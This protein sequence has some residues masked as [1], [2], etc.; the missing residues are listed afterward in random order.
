MVNSGT[1]T[2][3]IAVCTAVTLS[4]MYLAYTY[5]KKKKHTK[6]NTETQHQGEVFFDPLFD[7]ACELVRKMGKRFDNDDKLIF[8]GLYK[9]GTVGD[10]HEPQPS[11]LDMVDRYKW[12]KWVAFRGLTPVDARRA[13][14]LKAREMLGDS[15]KGLL[16]EQTKRH[17]DIQVSGELKEITGQSPDDVHMHDSDGDESDSEVE[18]TDSEDEQKGEKHTQKTDTNKHKEKK[19]DT[20]VGGGMGGVVSQSV[21]LQSEEGFLDAQEEDP[22]VTALCQAAA[23]GDI[24]L[25]IELLA[26]TSLPCRVSSRDAKRMTP[27]HWAADRGQLEAVEFL[28]D[29]GAEVNAQDD[30]GESALHLAVMAE[31]AKIVR[32]L[33]DRGG[34]CALENNEGETAQDMAEGAGGDVRDAFNWHLLQSAKL[35][36]A[37]S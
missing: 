19:T 29:R 18:F 27:L 14:V 31:E 20:N 4:A 34:D 3:V 37:D 5:V 33:I 16:D 17:S 11:L 25:M 28:L 12:E 8:Y 1:R 24:K 21:V 15:A 23:A 22:S 35:P 32:V 13:Y 10:C 7:K 30:H 9:Q 6:R 36:V 2:A 26:D